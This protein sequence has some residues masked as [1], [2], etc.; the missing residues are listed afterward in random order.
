MKHRPRLDSNQPAIVAGL[1]K[2]G[3][4]VQSLASIGKGCPDIL[5]GSQSQNYLFEIK[6]PSKPRSKQKLTDDEQ[7]WHIG[8]L[9]E[10]RVIHTL[11]EALRIMGLI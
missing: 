11:D 5:A 9:G 3:C 8:W 7:M 6:D 2:A 1:R 10:V 4:S